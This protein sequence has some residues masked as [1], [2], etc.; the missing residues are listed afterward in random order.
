MFGTS[1]CFFR[2][3]VQI[4]YAKSSCLHLDSKY[5]NYETN[6]FF[7]NMIDWHILVVSNT[8]EL[9]PTKLG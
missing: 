6:G 4:Y 2:E 9:F 7:Q 3:T 1:N 5:Y 8:T